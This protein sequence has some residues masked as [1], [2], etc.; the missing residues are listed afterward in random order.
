MLAYQQAR[1][2]YI[3]GGINHILLCTDGDFNIGPSSTDELLALVKRERQTGV[4]LTVLGFGIGN[5]NDQ[6]MER[7]SNA[8]NGI[9][10]VISSAT[11]A[12]RY[13]AARDSAAPRV[14]VRARRSRR[15]RPARDDRRVVDRRSRRRPWIL[16]PA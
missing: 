16:E 1:N 2:A 7:V 12:D 14:D 9:Y 6:M 4:T 13:D 11:H 5:L 10:G 8:G 3:E 15:A